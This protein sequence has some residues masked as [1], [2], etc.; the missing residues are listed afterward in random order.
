[1]IKPDFTRLRKALL[2]QGEPDIVPFFE[3]L[4]DRE[5]VA[6]ATG[7][8]RFPENLVQFFYESG[9]DCVPMGA[10]IPYRLKMLSIR[11]TAAFS[12]GARQFSDEN[13]GIIETRKD[14]DAYEWP[15][16]DEGIMAD[17]KE[18][19]RFLPDG[20]KIIPYFRSVFENVSFLMG[21][22]PL[23]YALYDDEQLVWDIIEKLGGNML[24]LV[25]MFVSGPFAAQI[26][27]VT[28]C[29]DMGFLTGTTVNPEFLRKFVFPWEKKAVDLLHAHDVPAILHAC[30]NLSDVMDDLIDYVGFDA[31][32]SF[33]DKILPVHEAKRKYGN[34]IALLG[35]VDIDFICT[36]REEQ[37]RAYVC[38]IIETCAPGGGYA[39]GTGNSVANYIP[40]EN[41]RIMLEEGRRLGAY[42]IN[43]QNREVMP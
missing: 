21:L 6:A 34:R 24:S 27:A 42:P 29:E 4:A 8:N 14:F 39:L 16:V 1:M 26:G 30:G 23:S 31:K 43:L 36:A 19:V 40:L 38:N 9:F 10:D 41:Y 20:M 33:E 25:E 32:H 37:I 2:R 22:V 3:L 15:E 5:F 7:N 17:L 35:G 28:L 13:H 12:R 18:V 11:D